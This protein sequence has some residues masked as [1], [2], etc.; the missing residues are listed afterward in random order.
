MISATGIVVAMVKD[1]PRAFGQRLHHDERED[2]EQDDHDREHADE[3]ECADRA[4]DFLLHH[5]A[6]RL[7]APPHGSEKHD[8]V[9]HAAA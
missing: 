3:R 5:L 9:V 7:P 1:A 8:H 2:R 4:A 6:E